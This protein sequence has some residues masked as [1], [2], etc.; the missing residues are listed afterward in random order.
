MLFSI[1]CHDKPDHLAL[2]MSTRPSHLAYLAPFA[3]GIVVAGP[4][5]D[6]QGQP[7]GS[8]FVL[9]CADRAAAEAFAAGD[10]YAEAGLFAATT[11]FGFRMVL[12]DGA[13]V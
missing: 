5:L 13:A 2:R 11:I 4:L 8:A 12:K 9:D 1:T 7:C 6:A 10:P 3:A